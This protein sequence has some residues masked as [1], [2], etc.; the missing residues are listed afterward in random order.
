[1]LLHGN[2][3]NTRDADYIDIN[4][5]LNKGFD[6]IALGHV[7][8]FKKYK[9]GLSIVG[10][11]IASVVSCNILTPYLRNFL[12]SKYQEAAVKRAKIANSTL[13]AINQMKPR[14]VQQMSSF[15]NFMV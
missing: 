5:F 13:F 7:H 11:L 3:E 8:Q 6:Y 12:A 15:K 9:N 14:N 1:M 2:I 10:T 4:N